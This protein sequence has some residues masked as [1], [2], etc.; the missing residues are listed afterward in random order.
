[1][2]GNLKKIGICALTFAVI[3]VLCQRPLWALTTASTPA[4]LLTKIYLDVDS[5]QAANT[6]S[7]G[8]VT[9]ESNLE[10]NELILLAKRNTEEISQVSQVTEV[11]VDDTTRYYITQEPTATQQTY[12][13]LYRNTLAKVTNAPR[14]RKVPEPSALVG[15]IAMIGWFGT[16]GQNSR[17]YKSKNI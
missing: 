4:T 11:R 17:T 13:P 14:K 7:I 8:E 10:A 6:L 15:L 2:A 5:H 12:T 3:G 9:D 16:Q 1:M